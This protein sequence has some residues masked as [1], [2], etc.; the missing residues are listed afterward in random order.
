[1]WLPFRRRNVVTQEGMEDAI[2]IATQDLISAKF[3]NETFA[4]SRDLGNLAGGVNGCFEKLT[5]LESEVALNDWSESLARIVKLEER[6]TNLDA[7]TSSVNTDH[8][9][10]LNELAVRWLAQQTKVVN[11]EQ[12]LRALAEKLGFRMLKVEE[13]DA[14]TNELHRKLT[15]IRKIRAAVKK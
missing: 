11:V 9:G 6:Y 13:H 3:A 2:R 10:R 15:E 14:I 8:H 5:K 1:M 4:R 12:L 7:H